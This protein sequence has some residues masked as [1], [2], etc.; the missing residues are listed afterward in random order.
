MSRRPAIP[1]ALKRAVLV[2]AGHRCAIPTCRAPSPLEIDHIEPWNIVKEHV[3]ENLICLCSN[4]HNRK[5]RKQ[6]GL[7]KQSLLIYKANLSRT[8]NQ[9]GYFE[10]VIFERLI[11]ENESMILLDDIYV[12]F[13]YY[14]LKDGLFERGDSI[15]GNTVNG[16]AQGPFHYRLTNKGV[17]FIQAYKTGKLID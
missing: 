8:R 7:D 3:F 13:M 17:C 16:V 9:Y 5:T 4:C 11:Q 1:Q 12:P 2:E 15:T 14:S 10:N 6:D